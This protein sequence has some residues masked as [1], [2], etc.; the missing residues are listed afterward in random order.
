VLSADASGGLVDEGTQPL[1]HFLDAQGPDAV[2]VAL[3]ADGSGGIYPALFTRVGTAAG[4]HLLDPDA[5]LRYDTPE[6]R[7]AI[8][9]V[10]ERIPTP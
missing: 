7:R 10:L 4:E 3:E 5:R 2:A 9:S 8:A 6:A 1:T